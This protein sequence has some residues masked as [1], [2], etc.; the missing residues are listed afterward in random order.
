MPTGG[1][2]YEVGTGIV[3]TTLAVVV[4]GA[5]AFALDRG[6]MRASAQRLR[7]YLRSSP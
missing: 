3:S 7:R 5:V 4:F 6:D 1:S 2:V